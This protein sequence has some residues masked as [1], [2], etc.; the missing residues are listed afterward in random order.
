MTAGRIVILAL[1]AVSIP[2]AAQANGWEANRRRC[3]GVF[4]KHSGAGL[5]EL[6]ECTGLWQAYADPNEIK[7]FAKGLY[8]KAFQA[9]YDKAVQSGD[10][11]GKA[12]ALGAAEQ[13]GVPLRLGGG[14]GPRTP[15][16]VTP[17][18]RT[19]PPGTPTPPSGASKRRKWVPPRV[20][21]GDRKK[22]DKACQQ[23]IRLFRKGKRDAALAKYEECLQ[24]D[25]GNVSG[26][27]NSAAEYAYR[28]DAGKAVENLR[29]LV[30]IGTKDAL[31]RVNYAR[32]DKDFAPLHENPDY[33]QATGFARIK[34][35]N[36]LAEL[37]EHEV[38]R[39]E[40]TLKKLNHP[41]EEVGVDK[42]K[43]RKVPVIWYKPASAPTAYVMKKV[44]VHPG[45]VLTRITWKTEWD[46]IVSWG[47]GVVKRD[48]MKAPERD[49]S[50]AD[51]AKAEKK[52]DKLR[53]EQDKALREPEKASRKVDEVVGTP[54]RVKG[55]VDGSINKVKGT[56]DTIKKTGG[57]IGIFK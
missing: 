45:V 28:R 49:Y 43:N 1:I 51:P 22:A 37:G 16:R 8:Q 31:A 4:A 52:L 10:E 5:A 14:P 54:E 41:V 13:L 50:D 40:K 42:V 46:I 32:M 33:K 35:V 6:R 17:P 15:T 55:K 34:V 39:I 2:V 29:R 12:I 24:I 30:D 48:G 47:N 27:Y 44:V 3:E 38:E 21:D 56:L 20:S 7:P 18:G 36:S 53:W 57:K 19:P 23:G 9:L 11:N 26:L 25:P